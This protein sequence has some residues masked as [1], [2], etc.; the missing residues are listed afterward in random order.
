VRRW[1]SDLVELEYLEG[2]ASKGGQ[3]KATR[4]RLADRAPREELV[5]GLLA[6][7]ELRRHLGA[8]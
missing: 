2:E 7:E 1:L 6:P 4:Y 3:G 8:G 5:L